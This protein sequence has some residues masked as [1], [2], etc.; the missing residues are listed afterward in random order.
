MMIGAVT[1][2]TAEARLL[3]EIGWRVSAGG[4]TDA[5]AEVA[6]RQLVRQGATALISF[7]LAGGLDPACRPGDLII[8]TQVMDHAARETAQHFRCDPPLVALLGG[9]TGGQI[10]AGTEIAATPKDKLRLFST[11]A[12]AAID[13]ESGAVARV[14]AEHSLPFA[15]LRAICDPA[16]RTLPRAALIPLRPD[17][18]INLPRILASLARHPGQLPGLIAVGRDA[19]RARAALVR[20][21]DEIRRRLG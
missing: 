5:G 18:G 12:C 1:G 11:T 13:L 8:P 7:G 3:A 19:A 6:A 20:R 14:A 21:V 15:V 4:G 2:L 17:G 9:Q 10:L 16:A